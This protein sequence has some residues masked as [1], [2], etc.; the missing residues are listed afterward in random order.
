MKLCKSAE[1]LNKAI[2]E[3]RQRIPDEPSYLDLLIELHT[4]VEEDEM[5]P[6]KEKHEIMCLLETLKMMLWKHS[7]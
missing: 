3:K 4:Q 2:M 6:E 5:I 7:Y 1:E